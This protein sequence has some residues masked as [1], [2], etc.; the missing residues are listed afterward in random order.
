MYAIDIKSKDL[1]IRNILEYCASNHSFISIEGYERIKNFETFDGCKFEETE[2]LP[3][4]TTWP[5]LNFYILPLTEDNESVIFGEIQSKELLHHE[6]GIIH[7]QISNNN[8]R[9]FYG[10]DNLDPDCTVATDFF[11]KEFLAQLLKKGI[12]GKYEKCKTAT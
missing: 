3:R 10:C 2:T 7:I 8:E 11:Q 12:I 6:K 1:A 4:Q 5:K 9:V